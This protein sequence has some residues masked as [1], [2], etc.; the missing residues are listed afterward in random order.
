[1]IRNVT[2][3]TTIAEAE[4]WA[5][6]VAERT[7]GLLDHDSLAA[8]EALVIAPCTS[9]HMVGMKFPIDVLFVNKHR[10]VIRAIEGIKPGLS[11]TRIY[12]TAK[13]CIELPVGAIASSG[14]QVGDELSFEEVAG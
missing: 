12:F 2:R 1:M 4:V 11:F 6:T 10:R 14:T 3:D 7:K 8:G 9:I 5:R 13:Q